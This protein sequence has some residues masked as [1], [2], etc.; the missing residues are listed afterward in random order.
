MTRRLVTPGIRLSLFLLLGLGFAVNTLLLTSPLYMLQ[1]YDRVLTSRSEETLLALSGLAFF[2]LLGYGLLEVT[3]TRIMVDISV[4]VDRSLGDEVFTSLFREALL[5]QESVSAQPFRDMDTIRSVLSGYGIISLLDL[6]WAPFFIIL[7]FL[8]H[9]LLGWVAL[10][11]AIVT[12]II[13]IVSERLSRPLMKDTSD[14]QMAAARFVDGCLGNSDAIHAMGML[15][16]IRNRWLASYDLSVNTGAS[17]AERVSSFAGATKALR[18]ILQSTMLGTGAWL[19]LQNEAS[20]GVMI[21]A[22]IIFGRAL[23]PLEQ[24]IAASRGLLSAVGA[25]KRLEGLLARHGNDAEPMELPAPT[26]RLRVENLALVPPGGD[27]PLLQGVSFTLNTGEVLAI[28]G[29]SASGKSSLARSLLGLWRP[30]RGTVRLDDAE[31]SQWDGDALGQYIGYVPQ[32]VELLTGT[33]RENITRFR[34]ADPKAV[35]DAAVKARCHPMILALPDG[36]DSFIGAG[37][38]RLSG[39]Q[40]Q[41]VALARCLFGDPI[42]AVL[43]EPDANLDIEG[44][45]ALDKAIGG[46]K[47]RGAT[48]ILITHNTRLLR[49]ADK[50]MLLA[51]GTMGYFGSPRELMDKLGMMK[52]KVASEQPE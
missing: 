32:N 14:H 5:R 31:L 10:A 1:L 15:D 22:S 4:E 50:A 21:A 26:G 52:T 40:S 25:L 41:R 12:L 23:A 29:P 28:V 2:L 33:V 19:V 11:G 44:L 38:N 47:E 34:E 51:N 42:L 30:V 18:I 9:P 7:I 49:H 39:G 20:A 36:Y 45:S 17:A 27:K 48:V 8:M 16:N 37:G 6:P 24:S 43:D 35:V 3:R 13:A 46:L